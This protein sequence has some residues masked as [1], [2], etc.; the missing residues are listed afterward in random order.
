MQL[1]VLTGEDG[2][3]LAVHFT[4]PSIPIPPPSRATSTAMRPAQGQ[5]LHHVELHS[6]LAQHVLANTLIQELQKWK[7]EGHGKSAKLVK[8]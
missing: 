6:E 2:G 1:N 8:R 3:I 7:V 4:T 5:S